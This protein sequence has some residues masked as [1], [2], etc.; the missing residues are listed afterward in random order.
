M[1]DFISEDDLD[2]FEGWLKGV[3]GIDP[4]TAAPDVL[5]QYQAM[6]DEISKRLPPQGRFDEA[7]SASRRTSVRGGSS[8]G[9]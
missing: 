6:F 4:T 3:Q 8:G 1:T 9:L 5:E 2:T 7:Q